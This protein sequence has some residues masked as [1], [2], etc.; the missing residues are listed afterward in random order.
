MRNRSVYIAVAIVLATIAIW[1]RSGAD[2]IPTVVAKYGGDILWALTVFLLIGLMMP[3]RPTIAVAGI[4]LLISFLVEVSQLYHAPW[5]DMLRQTKIGA[6]VLGH[7][8]LW[9]DLVCYTIGIGM[10]V[11][12]EMVNHWL[13]SGS[14]D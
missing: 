3:T 4:A 10:G 9:S 2:I 13:K 6:L 11:L 14:G 7:G 5:I 12:A 8:F 1:T